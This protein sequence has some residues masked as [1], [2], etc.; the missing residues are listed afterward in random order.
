MAFAAL[1]AIPSEGLSESEV[2]MYSA[3]KQNIEQ[4]TGQAGDNFYV[5]LVRGT[6]TAS[7]VES[8]NAQSVGVSGQAYVI[9][10][11]QVAPATELIALAGTVQSVIYDVKNVRDALNTLII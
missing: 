2:R 4:L 7:V 3:V 10:N 9:N 1:P 11:L 6:I 5:A 8:V